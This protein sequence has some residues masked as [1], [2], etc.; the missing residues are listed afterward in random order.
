M[1]ESKLMEGQTRT[2]IAQEEG[3]KSVRLFIMPMINLQCEDITDII[4]SKSEIHG[5]L[6]TCDMSIDA[7]TALTDTRN[8]SS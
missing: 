3:D 4:D 7:L 8:R 1:R 5:P 2:L 6:M